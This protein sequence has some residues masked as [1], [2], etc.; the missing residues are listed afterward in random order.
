MKDTEEIK[1]NFFIQKKGDKYRR[2][3]PLIW[4]G[5]YRIKEQLKT[6]FTLRTFFTIAIIL[7][8]AWSYQNDIGTYQDFYL[9]VNGDPLTYC[10]KVSE[11]INV[12]CSEQNER[13]GLCIRDR[14]SLIN[15]SFGEI[16]V[17]NDKD[18]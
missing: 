2:V 6:V 11:A 8:V 15:F 9:E 10:A 14:S 17:I 7:F 5:K 18:T 13:K 12:P 4:N 16:E 1:P 3:Y